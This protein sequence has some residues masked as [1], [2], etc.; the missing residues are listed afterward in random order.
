M[1]DPVLG[2]CS[3]IILIL[4][5]ISFLVSTSHIQSN[6]EAEKPLEQA[7]S[8]PNPVQQ[9]YAPPPQ[10]YTGPVPSAVPIYSEKLYK[11]AVTFC[12]MPHSL[13]KDD[14]FPQYRSKPI[15]S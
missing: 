11:D 2:V 7:Q 6:R 5:T 13:R 10:P 8:T 3:T 4:L 14:E 1:P 12:G 15:W 9:S